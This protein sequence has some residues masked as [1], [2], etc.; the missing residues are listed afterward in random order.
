MQ[1]DVS[2]DRMSAAI[3]AIYDSAVEPALWPKALEA[4]C[5]L[6]GATFGSLSLYDLQG[7]KKYFTARWGGDPYWIELLQTKY[8]KLDPFWKIYPTFQ[9]GDVASNDGE[10]FA[11]NQPLY[12][13]KGNNEDFDVIAEALNGHSPADNLHYLPNGGPYDVGPWRVAAL[14]GTFVINDPFWWS[15][16]DKFFGYSLASRLGVAIPRTVMLPQKDYIPAIDKSRSLRNLEFPLSWEAIMDYVKFPAI[17]KPA[18][19]GGWRDVTV[20][21]NPDELLAAYNASNK[22]VMTLQEFIDFESAELAPVQA[23]T[24]LK[25]LKVRAGRP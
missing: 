24:V 19:G 18:D 20:V 9:V 11:P 4:C 10:Y 5:G 16:D 8:V 2:A 12:W 7:Q 23:E 15:A 17:L 13:I 14:G 6:I 22:N 3:G 1:A 25:L 21:R